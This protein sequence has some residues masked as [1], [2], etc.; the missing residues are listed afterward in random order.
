[1]DVDL[2]PERLGMIQFLGD[3]LAITIWYSLYFV[4]AALLAVLW[5]IFRRRPTDL[6]P[7][8]RRIELML[9]RLARR[10][11]LAFVVVGLAALAGR[12]ALAPLLPLREPF[13]TDEFS[14]LLAAD[15]FASGR[16]TNPPHPMWVHFETI[17]VNQQPTYMSMYPPAQ[18]LALA[19]GEVV[20]GH[21]W[22]GVWLST[23]VMCAALC[24]MLQG[25]LP[26]FWALVGGLLAVVRLGL[27][28]YWMNS[29]WGGAVAATGGALV[30]GAL[31]RIIRKQRPW[32][33]VLLAVGLAVLASS[34]P[35]EGL[36]LAVPVAVVMAMWGFRQLR[37]SPI[38]MT[39]SVVAPVIVV[40]GLTGVGLGY[41]NQRLTGSARRMPYQ[42]N[43]DTYVKARY[44]LWDSV[45][46]T[47]VYR[48]RSMQDFYVTWQFNRSKA[49]T[50]S[51]TGFLANAAKDLG[52]FW[53]FYLGPALT[54]PL[55]MLPWMW[56]D[57]R[58]RF[59]LVTTVCFAGGMAM[60]L[61]FYPHYAAPLTGVLY[62]VLV[63]GLR[64]LRAAGRKGSQ[65]AAGLTKAIPMVCLV[66]VLA[67]V[68]LSPFE[69][70]LPPDY[71]MTWYYTRPGNVER[72]GILSHLLTLPGN[73]LVFVRYKPGHN[74][75]T[76]WVYNRADIDASKVVWAHDMGTEANAELTRYFGGR[77]AWLVEPD[78]QPPRLRPY[79]SQ[80]SP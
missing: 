27:F 58:I 21:P 15:T 65:S 36:L 72:A 2:Y 35:Y 45:N 33:A 26:P 6:V 43:R 77:R 78:E 70:F 5:W 10:R 44:F 53:L 49:A 19:A 52:E 14:Y 39:T 73:D 80:A 28:S 24:W 67:R 40:L 30:L 20:E 76:E 50:G 37:L 8:F 64:H 38:K 56:R 1:M 61:F 57:R 66:I 17:H 34:R 46:P 69:R 13:I 29:Y 59:L 23:G 16:L 9:G 7:R 62:V 55:V 32:D 42:V 74:W 63:Q 68:F 25:W 11:R 75:F 47:P 22:F 18:A 51:A 41:Y 79:R 4:E 3:L 54:A 31:P 48:H 12:A 71:P 60:L